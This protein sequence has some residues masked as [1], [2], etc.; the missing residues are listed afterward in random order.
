MNNYKEKVAKS[1]NDKDSNKQSD[2][3]KEIQR[4]LNTA[5]HTEKRMISLEVPAIGGLFQTDIVLDLKDRNIFNI[6]LEI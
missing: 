6:A 4:L 2:K 5:F 3:Q 1:S